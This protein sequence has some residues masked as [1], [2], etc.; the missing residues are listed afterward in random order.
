VLR[1]DLDLAGR[2]ST[3]RQRGASSSPAS[4]L[5]RASPF[6]MSGRPSARTSRSTTSPASL[7]AMQEIFDWTFAQARG[8][9]GDRG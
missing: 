8:M 4:M 9:T 5:Y 2:R 7:P 1:R 3:Q 6:P